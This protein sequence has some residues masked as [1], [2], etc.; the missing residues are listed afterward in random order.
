[1]NLAQVGPL[2]LACLSVPDLYSD[3]ILS[4]DCHRMRWPS[5]SQTNNLEKSLNLGN[6]LEKS[7]NLIFP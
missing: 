3:F 7:L 4:K 5:F 6:C 1:M 2:I